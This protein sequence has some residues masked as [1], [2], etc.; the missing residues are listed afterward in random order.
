MDRPT[1]DDL[2]YVRRRF[3]EPLTA[4]LSTLLGVLAG[5]GLYGVMAFDAV[6]R[7]SEIGMRLALGARPA[8]VSGWCCA[9]PW[10]W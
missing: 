1:L 6:W 4:G 2:L 7:T 3:A 8:D 9:K 5:A 10:D